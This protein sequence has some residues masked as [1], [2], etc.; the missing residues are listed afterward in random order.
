MLSRSLLLLVIFGG[1]A[2]C[3][4]IASEEALTPTYTQTPSEE[5]AGASS[6]PVGDETES[7]DIDKWEQIQVRGVMLGIEIPNG[8]SAQQIEDGLLLAEHFGSM[9]SGTQ[10]YG[11][12]IHLFVYSMDG[13]KR[14]NRPD[15]NLAWAMLKQIIENPY[16]I[17]HAKVSEP[18]GFEWDGHDAAYY[19]LN[20]GDGNLS[21]L[22]A[23]ALTVPP[24][25]VVCNFS[26]PVDDATNIRPMLPQ[27]LSSLTINGASMDVDAIHDLPD[28]LQFPAAETP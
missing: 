7:A 1:M 19:L 12:Q 28:P 27:I 10:V 11:M 15:T 6:T 23:V 5:T 25:L 24:R 26:S 18:A 14:P 20:D 9:Q 22:L 13:F 8:W 3:Q 2:A 16:L 17:G 21:V 4:T